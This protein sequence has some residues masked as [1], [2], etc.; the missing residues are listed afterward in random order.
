VF[1]NVTPPESKDKKDPMYVKMNEEYTY[2]LKQNK[3]YQMS[4]WMSEKQFLCLNA[5]DKSEILG[6]LCNEL[7]NNKAVVNQIEVTVDNV[8]ITRRRKW[9]LENKIKKL[10]MLHARKFKF[11]VDLTKVSESMDNSNGVGQFDSKEPSEAGEDKDDTMSIM[12]ESTRLSESNLDSPKKGKGKKKNNKKGGKKKLEDDL[13]LDEDMSE[14]EE[15]SEMGDEIQ[16][17]AED[18]QLSAEDLQKKIDRLNKQAIKKNEEHI[19]VSNT[20]R[21]TEMGQ[22]RYRRRY[23]HL[24]HSG[25]TFVEGMESAEPWKIPTGGLREGEE[26]PPAKKIKVDGSI[27]EEEEKE[28][29]E[30]IKLALTSTPTTN[31]GRD[32]TEEALKK[33]GSEIMVTPKMESKWESSYTPKVTPNGDNLNL[34]NHSAYFNMSVSPVILNGSVTITPKEWGSSQYSG[35]QAVPS[36]GGVVERPWFSIICKSRETCD[37]KPEVEFHPARRNLAE[38]ELAPQI[39]FLE[40]KLEVVKHMDKESTRKAT[41]PDLCYGWWK[42]S[43]EE[44]ISKVEACLL[45]KGTREQNLLLNLKRASEAVFESTKKLDNEEISL[46]PPEEEKDE[47]DESEGQENGVKVEEIVSGAPRPCEAGSWSRSVALRVDKYILDQVEA[48]EDKVAAASMQVPGWKLPERNEHDITEFRPSCEHVSENDPRIDPI[49]LAKKR[50]LDLEANIE[51]RYLK[52]PLGHSNAGV[53]LKTITEK[54]EKEEEDVEPTNGDLDQPMDIDGESNQEEPT[55][56]AETEASEVNPDKNLEKEIPRGLHNWREGVKQAKNAA[57]LAMGFYVLE[58]SIAWHKS[59]MKASCQFCHCGDNEEALLLCD[60][61]DK[62]YHTY[63]FK[64]PITDIP[65]GDWYCFEC[66]NKATGLRHCLVCGSQEEKHLILCATCPRAYHADCIQP[67]MAKTPRG[68]WHCPGCNMKN[69]KK[70]SKKARP[71]SFQE[72]QEPEKTPPPPTPAEEPAPVEESPPPIEDKPKKARP[73]KKLDLSICHTL[74]SELG[75]HEEAWPFLYPVPL[76]Q[77]PTYK[78]IIRNPMDVSTIR[79]KLNDGMYKSREEFKGDVNLIFANCEIF[80]EDDSPVG[81]AGH[82]MKNFFNARWTELTAS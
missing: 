36:N 52:A 75:G 10:R 23:W 44:T 15:M 70:K 37:S 78:K 82:S 11:R 49:A 73:N 32:E 42:I 19:F 43:D 69:P 30:N 39:S 24:A 7:L 62:G 55:E 61:C 53:S 18:A 60:G 56:N 12:S 65:E 6:F 81:K 48:L 41:P 47:D 31:K 17:E 3:T 57:Q 64:P 29:K 51:R 4:Q 14:D 68:K 27:K 63:C 46:M 20:L 16:E 5:L 58:T 21:A 59:I 45:Q 34:F 72:R 76:K 54:Q 67:N 22:D 25:G 80:N 50:L 13:D 71:L 26:E 33:L 40:H 1:H 74:L 79:K 38:S 28:N 8:H 66:I 9:S 35:G 2:L 77:F